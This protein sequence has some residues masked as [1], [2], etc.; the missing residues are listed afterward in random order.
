[1]EEWK[2]F[3]ESVKDDWTAIVINVCSLCP[4]CAKS[5]HETYPLIL[6]AAVL[7]NANIAFLAIPGAFNPSS[8]PSTP[9]TS[10]S[11]TTIS[12][13]SV[14]TSNRVQAIIA[15]ASQVSMVL[16]LS[17]MIIGMSLLKQSGSARAHSENELVSTYFIP[18]CAILYCITNSNFQYHFIKLWRTTRIGLHAAAIKFSIPYILLMYRY[19][20][21]SFIKCRDTSVNLHHLVWPNSTIAFVVALSTLALTSQLPSV[22]WVFSF[23]GVSV[24]ILGAWAIFSKHIAR[25]LNS[26]FHSQRVKYSWIL[27]IWC[28]VFSSELSMIYI[29]FCLSLRICM[30]NKSTTLFSS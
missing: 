9:S 15:I 6:Q 22:V 27:V 19:A 11:S 24:I 12:A 17:S 7:L 26:I 5:G 13:S 30:K 4:I 28:T 23:A 20:W 29:F 25:G 16:S 18:P 2:P 14:S 10:S 21:S 1:M 8:A 3:F